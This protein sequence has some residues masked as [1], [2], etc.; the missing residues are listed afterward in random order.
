[1]TGKQGLTIRPVANRGMRK[2]FVKLPWSVYRGNSLWAPPLIH[3]ELRHFHPG[4]NPFFDHSDVQLFLAAR[5]RQPV[6]RIAAFVNR[7]HNEFH[8][9]RTGFFG[10]FESLPDFSVAGQL[11]DA[12]AHWLKERGMSCMR[13]PMNFSTNEVCG[14][15]LEGF[16]KPP[17]TMMPYTPRYYLDFAQ[18][19]GF[20]KSKDLYAYL[21]TE[22]LFAWEKYDP[23]VRLVKERENIM[24][25]TIN[26]KRWPQE[27]ARIREVYNASWSRNWGF[28]PMTEA[29]FD[30]L[31]KQIKPIVNPQLVLL[32]EIEGVPA[33]FSLSLPDISP[34]LKKANGRLFP[35]GLFRFMLALRKAQQVRVILLAIRPDFQKRGLAALLITETARAILK[36]GYS[37]AEM[38]WTLEDNVLINKALERAGGLAYKK[39]RIFEVPL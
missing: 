32:L 33:G 20:R 23:L 8:N 18:E 21:I 31:A 24:V 22:K 30:H 1:M 19:Y 39:Y 6:G 16:D 3:D 12:A 28:V 34:A 15:L 17:I 4:K 2:S 37:V 35:V 36:A 5:D 9:D 27:A 29:E 25:R 11:F 7:S 13:G 38:S 14:F 10:F 26:M